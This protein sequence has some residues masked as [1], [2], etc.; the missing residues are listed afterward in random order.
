M[1]LIVED[2]F[3][4]TL[5]D[6]ETYEPLDRYTAV[7]DHFI[8]PIRRLL[9]SDWQTSRKGV[10]FHCGP[11]DVR[12]PLQG[13][14]IHVSATLGNA[15]P[16]LS[17]VA[18]VLVRERVPFKF[19]I[20]RVMLFFLNFKRW[21]RGGAG[22]FVT[23]YPTDAEQCGRLLEALHQA[24]VGFNGPYILS[25]RRYRDSSVVYYR[26]GGLLPVR[27][28]DAT[29]Q[30]RLVMEAPDGSVVDDERTPYFRLPPGVTDPFCE[31]E[32]ASAPGE[33]TLK[34][35]RYRIESAIAFSNSG[36]VYVAR[37]V[38]TGEKVLVKEA[39]PFTNQSNRGTDAVWL[40]KKEHRLLTILEDAGVAPRPIDFFKEWEH[41]YLVEEFLEGVVL[42]FFTAGRA[43]S[44]RVRPTR[45]DAE[46][47]YACFSRLFVR[48]ARVLQVLHERGIVFSDL[49]L[50]NLLVLDADGDDVRLIDFEGAYEQGVDLPT[51]LF[52]PGFA[53]EQVKDEGQSQ[54]ED[55]LYGLGSLM[56]AT[57]HPIN[58]ISS[59]VR[60]GHEPFLRALV[61]DMSLPVEIADL[62]RGLLH[63]ERSRRTRIPEVIRVLEAPREVRAP[64][65]GT[66]EADVE[67]LE[68]LLRRAMA[69][70][71]ASA[72]PERTDRLFPAA[73]M[74]YDTN[75]LSVAFGACGVAYAMK[76]V[77]GDVPG[78]VVDWILSREISPGAYPPGLYVGT[79]GIAWTLLDL[80]L[81]APAESLLRASYDH[82][83]LWKSP[84]LFNGA[85]GWGMANL[86][87]F[88]QTGDELYLERA[89]EAGRF[90]L[91]TRRERDGQAWWP[92]EGREHCGL[93]HGAAGVSLFLLYL[94][95]ATGAEP[96]L[97]AGRMALEYVLARGVR[98]VDGGLT[99]RVQEGEPTHTPYW[100]WGS[101]GVG[102][103]LLR[104]DRAL[105]ESRYAGPLGE[106]LLD[107]DRKYSIFAGRFNGLSGIG[108]FWLDLAEGEHGRGGALEGARRALSGMLL[109]KVERP[110]GLAFPGEMRDR[111][112][113]DFGTGSA[114]NVLFVE[115]LLRGGP[116]PFM[117]DELVD[118]AA[119]AGR[120]GSVQLSAPV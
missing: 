73:P 58:S 9:P 81:R 100:R 85:S 83:V 70:I 11:G 30:Q 24:T 8:G 34:N 75:P 25:D 107:A 37:D 59:L 64:S 41:Y 5:A 76:R 31:E 92:V 77:E 54:A 82:P 51:L 74:V 23:V 105:G 44:L 65:V 3:L 84:D 42:R 38:E 96:Y 53:P 22:K 52:T 101:A 113:C 112:C 78:E 103:V 33:F 16:L 48:A 87:F 15:S 13:W 35:G 69:F 63:P 2:S 99:W 55:D 49:S 111:I 60:D 80:G 36:G 39:R 17:M 57:L 98:N 66:H 43:L 114:G 40:L 6:R 26:Y 45:D 90:L 18:R 4:Y 46:A 47:Y 61:R 109:F 19:A 68:A 106:I 110:A 89:G 118:A 117:L 102:S 119:G 95:L 86:R 94:H 93:G 29:G 91:E 21:P 97:A 71:R 120:T 14:K 27:V 10:W 1:A 62:V 115:R 72:T 116:P 108:D 12:L 20:D 32:P 88:L 56:L 79:A 28:L 104:Y 67:D 50:Y 7:E